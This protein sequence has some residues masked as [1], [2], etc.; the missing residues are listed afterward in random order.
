MM[1][2]IRTLWL[3]A[4][5]L[6]IMSSGARAAELLTEDKLDLVTAGHGRFRSTVINGTLSSTAGLTADFVTSGYISFTGP[7]Q[8]DVMSTPA[9]ITGTLS[10]TSGLTVNLITE[11]GIFRVQPSARPSRRARAEQSRRAC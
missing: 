9:T 7:G 11:A 3:L 6:A 5:V 8:R 1:N 10:S 4:S 2:C